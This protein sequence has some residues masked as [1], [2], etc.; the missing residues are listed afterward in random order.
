MTIQKLYTL[1]NYRQCKNCD[2]LFPLTDE[3]LLYKKPI[4]DIQMCDHN[5]GLIEERLHFLSQFVREQSADRDSTIRKLRKE[6]D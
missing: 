6:V 1:M 3:C 2:H 4:A 5:K